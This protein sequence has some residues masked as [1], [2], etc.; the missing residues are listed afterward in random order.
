MDLLPI[1]H[2][3]ARGDLLVLGGFYWG[4]GLG[5]KDFASAIHWETTSGDTWPFEP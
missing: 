2:M 1:V 4:A 3:S 5:W